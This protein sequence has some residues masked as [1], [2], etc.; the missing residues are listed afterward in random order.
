MGA[1]THKD[2]SGT[3]LPRKLGVRDG[4]RVLVV[5]APDGFRL[6]PLPTGVELVAPPRAPLDVA[7]TRAPID[8]VRARAPL[9]VVLLFVTRHSDLR[10]RFAGLA[11]AL[12]PAGRLW[13]AWPKKASRLATDLTF[14]MVQRV[15]LDDG[16]VD[17]KSGSIDEEFQGL[18]FVYRLKDRPSR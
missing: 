17:N 2:Y 3:P 6:E 10:R 7:R 1:K 14:E 9:D 13:V 16:L 8:T 18:Q 12:A 15:G 11:R 5:G 4:S